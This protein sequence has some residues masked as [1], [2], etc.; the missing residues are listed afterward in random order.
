MRIDG[1][2]FKRGSWKTK[3]EAAEAEAKFVD[4]MS[5]KDLEAAKIT[6]SD[7]I[8]EYLQHEKE[9]TKPSTYKQEMKLCEHI[10][11][12]LGDVVIEKLTVSR[13]KQFRSDLLDKGLSV[14]YC[15]K[16]INHCKS[17]IKLMYVRYGVVTRVPDG[18]SAMKD[19]TIKK[20]IDFYSP[21]EF[22]KFIGVIDPVQEVQWYAFFIVSYYCGTRCGENN[23]LQ[24]KDIDFNKKTISIS[25]TVNT[26]MRDS[27]G[28]YLIGSPKTKGSYRTL[29]M[30]DDV[31]SALNML[32]K[33]WSKFEGFNK[34]WFLYGGIKPMPESNIHKFNKNAAKRA[35]LRSI[36]IHGYRHSCCSFLLSQ[37]C[38]ILTVAKYLGHSD[39]QKALNVY[40]HLMPNA[41]EE[42]ANL[43]NKL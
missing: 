32:Y 4:E 21:E 42:A 14:G 37:G 24:W 20:E 26:K 17:I 34:S 31:F 22:K 23:A 5:Y 2:Q 15:N 40:G 35:G 10:N 8:S 25:K 9:N 19:N 1:K 12:S 36:S 43:F 29:P 41:L 13:Y 11:S 30:A 33:Y 7:A 38:T 27:A 6:F 18:F 16:I 3:K 39:V 28:N